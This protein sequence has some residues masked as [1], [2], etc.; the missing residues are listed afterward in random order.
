M[1]FLQKKPKIS[2]DQIT[3]LQEHERT[4]NE[5]PPRRFSMRS[6]RTARHARTEQPELDLLKVNSSFPSPDLSNHPMD[7]NRI[8][9]ENEAS[10]GD[11]IPTNFWPQTN[12]NKRNRDSTERKQKPKFPTELHESEVKSDVWGGQDHTQRCT[13]HPL[14]IPSKKFE[15]KRLQID[16]SS[17]AWKFPKIAW[18]T[19]ENYTS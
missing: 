12:W 15:Q 6:W 19:H 17:D 4:T 7:C 11:A 16:E 14:V 1:N 18:K 10:L 3:S 5:L 9:G 13:R 2:K 8:I